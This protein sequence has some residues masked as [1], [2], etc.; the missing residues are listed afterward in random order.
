MQDSIEPSRKLILGA[1]RILASLRHSEFD[2]LLLEIGIDE[3]NA[4]RSVGSRHARAMAAG[5]YALD[6]PSLTTHEGEQL[7]FWLVQRA[8]NVDYR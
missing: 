4:D 3:I 7:G 6:H 1:C 2:E 8:G 5:K